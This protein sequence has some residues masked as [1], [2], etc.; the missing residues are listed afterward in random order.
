[1]WTGG[2]VPVRLVGTWGEPDLEQNRRGP[3]WALTIYRDVIND[4]YREK[5]SLFL[6]ILKH[7]HVH[8]LS[9][10]WSTHHAVSERARWDMNNDVRLWFPPL[11]GT[12][13]YY[14]A[15]VDTR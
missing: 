7:S 14:I 3:P 8:S 6:H 5:I 10:S 2:R 15:V 1:M 9:T 12:Y 13:D 11:S 4:L